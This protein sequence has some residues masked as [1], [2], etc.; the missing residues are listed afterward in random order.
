MTTILETENKGWG[1]WGTAEGYL[2]HKKGH[3]QIME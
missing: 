2:K 3:D 1:F